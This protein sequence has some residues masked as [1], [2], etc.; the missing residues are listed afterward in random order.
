MKSFRQ[1]SDDNT[2]ILK[3][4][5]IDLEKH[6]DD[7]ANFLLARIL[8]STQANRNIL[9]RISNNLVFFFW[10]FIISFVLII[11]STFIGLDVLTRL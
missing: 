3:Q 9:E 5:P 4:T 10:A 2:K 1:A 8:L 7:D 11:L 6:I